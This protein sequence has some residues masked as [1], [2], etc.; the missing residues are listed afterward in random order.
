MT[1]R[2]QNQ[3]G[4]PVKGI[5]GGFGGTYVPGALEPILTEIAEE[6]EQLKL[7]LWK[8]YEH[9]RDGYTEAKTD[10]VRQQTAEARMV[11]AGR[12]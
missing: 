7:G 9:D 5:Y 12:Y 3:A 10:F 2:S 6:Y 11:Y 4:F 1:E 8:R